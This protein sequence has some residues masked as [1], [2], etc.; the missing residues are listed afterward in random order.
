[1]FIKICAISLL[2]GLVFLIVDK[3]SSAV[4]FSVKL[5][6]LI[7]LG[8]AIMLMIE[9]VVSKIYEFSSLSDKIGE[10]TDII[11]K[12]LGVALL[13]HISADVC[14]D[15]KESSAANAVILAAK[16]EILILCLPLVEK[17]IL[18][19]QDILDMQ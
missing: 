6:A 16:I 18:Y 2:S 12:V 7:L 13:S 5:S 9:P 11:L 10:Y 1:M 17:I 4:S 19:A 3:M 14:R 15:C 8:G